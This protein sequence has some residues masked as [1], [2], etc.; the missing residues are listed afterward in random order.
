MS[1]PA[2][3]ILVVEDDAPIRTF[4]E[5]TLVAHGYRCSEASTAREALLL[6]TTQPPDVVLLDLGLPDGDGLDLARRIRSWSA[7]PIIVISAR[8]R[9]HDKV[10]ALDSGADDYLTK[11]FGVPELL[12]RIR[13]SLRHAAQKDAAPGH[14]HD[15]GDPAGDGFR[16]DLARRLVYRFQA[17][18]ESEVKLSA[19][20]LAVL[21]VL[22]RSSGKV[23]THAELLRQVWGTAHEHEVAYL[24]VYLARL[25][26]KLEP[27]PAHPRWLLT[28]PGIG[29]RLVESNEP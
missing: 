3:H 24:R 27:E 1:A 17:G 16:V 7:V 18:V 29:Y 15:W 9:E 21:T 23:L 22:V 25:R 19:R 12:A 5:T 10:E 11:P 2:P 20:E 26:R 28:E 6:M 14:E 8:G 13:V 4:L